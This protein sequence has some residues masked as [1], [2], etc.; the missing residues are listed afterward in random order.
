M[1]L[2]L[3]A[4]A[5]IALYCLASWRLGQAA[6]VERP[7]TPLLLGLAAVL[8]HAAVHVT[9]MVRSAALPL[10]FFAALSWVAFG[11]AALSTG[12]A[13]SRRF[14]ALG[15]LVYPLAALSLLAFVMLPSALPPE[16]LD[17]PL[18]LH[19]MLALLAYTTLALTAALAMLLAVQEHL[20]RARRL[21]H[22]LLR[23]LPPL[24][25]LES[26]MFRTLS[27]GFVL[28]TLALTI[29][30]VFV[31]N[32][33]AQHLVHKSV[34]SVLAW[35][36]FGVLLFGRRRFGWRGRRAVRLILA[37]MVLLLL[38]FFG[39]KFVLELLL[40]RGA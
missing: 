18:R 5:A 20:L 21:D 9:D 19:A 8:I 30:T 16:S 27:A 24:T 26:L 40:E 15:S 38:A 14:E 37:A 31:E 12:V 33:F 28:L 34:L 10:H 13:W 17:W 35:I 3:P 1:T 6:A 29:G 7:T 4:I 22:P 2:L 11:M 23:L 36:V 32:L 25:E 39:S